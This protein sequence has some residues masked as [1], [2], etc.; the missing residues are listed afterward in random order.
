MSQPGPPGPPPQWPAPGPPPQWGPPG[1]APAWQPPPPRL[2]AALSGQWQRLSPLSPLV[3][4]GPLLLV[5][6]FYAALGAAGQGGTEALIR[7]AVVGLIAVLGVVNWLVTRW[8]IADGALQI[9]TGLLR[10]QS[11]RFPLTQIQ[12]VDVVQ[13]ALARIFGLAEMRARMA[14]GSRSTGRLAYMPLADAEFV[15]TRLLELSQDQAAAGPQMGG[16]PPPAT[17]FAPLYTVN[18]GR[19][20][21]SILLSTPALVVYTIIVIL[22]VVA[23]VSPSATGGAVGGS[24]GLLIAY[25]AAI[26]GRFNALYNLS[27][28]A[29]PDGLHMRSGLIQTTTET[30]PWGRIQAIRTV[31]P[32][33][34]R[35]LGWYR[36]EADVAG[37]GPSGRNDRAARR[38]GRA[39]IPVGHKAE[40][41]WL[42]NLVMPGA[43]ST[44]SRP[45]A[46]ARW[47]APV[48]FG[49]LSFSYN[50][51]YAVT[52]S[53]R[54][55]KVTDRVPL[56]KIQSLRWTEGPVQRRLR[57][58]SIHF[59]TAGRSVYAV[60]RDRDA[61]EASELIATLPDVCRRAR[62]VRHDGA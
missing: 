1:S 53:G 22:I 61:G 20:V 56:T 60:A 4:I 46:R 18:G 3:R 24:T 5:V 33:L 27:L 50:D 42:V 29:G 59:D 12:A 62:N 38:A 28:G 10:R 9:D 37:R 54:L 58:A 25:V 45:P 30:I 11:L 49:R 6:V 13:P 34:W 43:P 47:K 35:P 39:L 55:R 21:A 2:G 31:Q 26:W 17:T 7:L 16:P 44:G 23:V 57:L 14:S 52:T 32:F 48:R 15:R 19:L 36:V 51:T 40:A 8:R 41:D